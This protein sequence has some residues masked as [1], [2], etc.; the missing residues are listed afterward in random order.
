[1]PVEKRSFLFRHFDKIVCG[2]AAIV[3][4][5][6]AIVAVRRNR[7]DEITDLLAGMKRDMKQVE[8]ELFKRAP[9]VP[10]TEYEEILAERSKVEPPEETND[11][12]PQ[13]GVPYRDKYLPTEQE[14]I[15]SFRTQLVPETLKV[16][17]DAAGEILKIVEFPVGGDHTKVKVRTTK[18]E[19]AVILTAETGRSHVVQTVYVKKGMNAQAYPPL[20]LKVEPTRDGIFIRF[21]P[22][23]ANEEH[24]AVQGYQIYKEDPQYLAEGFTFLWLMPAMESELAW[25]RVG[26][27]ET[28]IAPGAAFSQEVGLDR[29]GMSAAPTETQEPGEEEEGY[30]LLDSDVM[31][32]ESYAYKI[33]AVPLY[34]YQKPSELTPE[35]RAETLPSIDFRYIAGQPQD[36]RQTRLKFEIAKYT[37]RGILKATF[38]NRVG[39]M[40]GGVKENEVTGE[41][42]Y[43]LTGC[44]LL[45]CHWIKPEKGITYG[46]I[47]YVDQRG[48]LKMRWKKE[49]A[50]ADLWDVGG[51][52]RE[53]AAVRGSGVA[54]RAGPERPTLL[55]PSRSDRSREEEED[56]RF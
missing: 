44:Y 46:R 16:T 17:G 19:G 55:K 54:G 23:R 25:T 34:R 39:D 51:V 38:Q 42:E 48:R 40:I 43:F 45:D 41:L 32:D 11:V 49:V 37:E 50:A 15:L 4:V 22:N 52:W 9:E 5:L 47:T 10:A 56:E 13:R 31:P 27:T 53:P 28:A 33:R 7:G 2:V 8:I 14:D 35:V 12:V 18:E 21:M 36:N 3:F 30:L 24:V 29:W 26:L 6:V 20:G 1:M